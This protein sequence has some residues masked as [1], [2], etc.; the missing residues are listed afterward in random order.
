MIPTAVKSPS[1]WPEERRKRGQDRYCKTLYPDVQSDANHDE[2]PNDALGFAI[3]TWLLH[4][5]P[6]TCGESTAAIYRKLLTSLRTYLQAQNLDLDSPKH[7]LA[8]HIQTWA[9]LRAPTSKHLGDVAPATYN[10]RIAA[11]RSFYDWARQRDIYSWP[12]PTEQ[13]KRTAVRKYAGSHAL[14]VQQ[15]RVQL[16]KID[17]S[18]PRGQRDYALLQVALNTGRGARELASLTLGSISRHGENITLTF[19]GGRSGK[20]MYDTLDARLSQTLLAYLHTIYGENLRAL[21]P[22]TPIWISFS[23]RTSRQAIG[24]Q[25]IADI[26]EVHLGV[27]R[28]HRLRHTFALAMDELG[29]PVD[30]IQ[31][32]LG[33]E[34]RSTTDVYLAS[35]KE[36]RNPYAPLLADAFGVGD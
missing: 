15:V 4:N 27:S 20:V 23:D 30:T 19:G 5:Y 36:A 24:Q 28:V 26:C 3:E 35:L 1:E 32:R 22:Q 14:D 29:A 10:Q 12:N 13:L 16:K 7:Q 17:R 11:V 6:P 8:P 21:S 31:T 33:H 25:T 18:T 34:N 2:N 9:N